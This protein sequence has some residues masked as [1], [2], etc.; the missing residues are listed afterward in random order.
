MLK[1]QKQIKRW[2]EVKHK[3]NSI[4]FK[5]DE[6]NKWIIAQLKEILLF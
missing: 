1:H 6:Y 4:E 5:K 2:E 3:K